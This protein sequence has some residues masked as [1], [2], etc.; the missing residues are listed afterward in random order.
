MLCRSVRPRRLVAARPDADRTARPRPLGGHRDQP[1]V[2]RADGGRDQVGPTGRDRIDSRRRTGDRFAKGLCRHDHT[3]SNPMQS[4]FTAAAD[5]PY[6][7]ARKEL[8]EPDWRRYPGWATVTEAEW[9]DPQWQRSH[10]I[11]NIGQLRA[12]VG[13]LLDDAVLRRPGRRSAAAGDDVDAAAAADAEHDGSPL[14]TGTTAAS[15]RRSM[16]IRSGVTCCRCCSDREPEWGSHPFAE[17]DSL[18]ESDM[19][20]VEGLTHRYP[21]KVLAEMLSTCPQYCGH[22]TRMDLVGNSHAHGQQ[23]QADP[24]AGRPA[25]PDAGLS[26]RHADGA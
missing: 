20:V 22:C 2:L 21:T 23:D 26:A 15:P 17:R 25:G 11:K 1:G 4:G 24:A 19:W 9:R 16:P 12:V 14:R 18:H 7:Y 6:T 8:S 5:Q 3:Q 13:D 10:S